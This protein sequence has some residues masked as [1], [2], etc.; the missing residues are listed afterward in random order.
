MKITA[1]FNQV[2]GVVKPMHAVG[3]PPYP[4]NS[5]KMFHYLEEAGIPYSRLHDVNGWYGRNIYVDIPNI[6]RDFDAD[7]TRQESYDFAFTDCLM[8]SL[9]NYGV[10]PFYRL[11]ITIENAYKVKAYRNFAPKDPE[12]WARIC[13]HIIRHYNEGWADGFHYN[14]T[15]WEI[16]NEPEGAE[17]WLG[18]PEEYFRLYEVTSRH[19][20]KCFGDTIKVGGPAAIGFYAMD[21]YPNCEVPQTCETKPEW[22][23]KWVHLFFDYITQEEHRCPMD[24]FSWHSYEDDPNV[25]VEHAKYCQ[26]MM[27]KYGL[28]GIETILN[29]WNACHDRK[30]KKTAMA[31]ARTFAFMLAMQRQDNVHMAN[32]Y[33]ARIGESSY[34]GMFNPDTWTPYKT[35]YAFMSFNKAYELKNEVASASDDQNVHVLAAANEKKAVLLIANNQDREVTAELELAGVSMDDVMILITDDEYQYTD[36][37]KKI[38]DGAVILP[39]YSCVELRFVR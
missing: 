13:E 22:Y 29:E 7:E 6:F 34:S 24:F 23:L 17:M 27:E 3:Q 31:A 10:E 20:K 9:H 28:T 38:K 19:L 25:S 1:D 39:P 37:G 30:L 15:Y 16:W 4:Y 12:K 2:T 8:T 21:K 11:G 26:K 14:V 35:Y 33:D 5:D 36:T 32:Y 18:T